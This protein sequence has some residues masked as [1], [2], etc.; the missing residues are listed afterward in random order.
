MR[1]TGKAPYIRPRPGLLMDERIAIAR[2]FRWATRH[3]ACGPPD[4]LAI[5]TNPEQLFAVAW[6]ACFQTAIVQVA[7][8][9]KIALP[10]SSAIDAEVDLNWKTTVTSSVLGSTLACPAL[11]ETVAQAL[12]N[13]AHQICAYSKATRGHIG[14]DDQLDLTS[15]SWAGLAAVVAR[16]AQLALFLQLLISKW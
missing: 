15:R 4:R 13:E 1:T 7:R 14:R 8:K 2:S 12:V 6:S 3:K 16:F 9:Q 10:A 5:G 11:I